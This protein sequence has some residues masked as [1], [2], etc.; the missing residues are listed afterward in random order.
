MIKNNTRMFNHS[1]N[2]T[3]PRLSHQ[4]LEPQIDHRKPLLPK[5]A[6]IL[7]SRDS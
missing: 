4:I 7:A 2:L 5:Q 6:F 1:F 3:L